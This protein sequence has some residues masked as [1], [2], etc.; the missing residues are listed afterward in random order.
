MSI[1]GVSASSVSYPLTQQDSQRQGLLALT[2][3]IDSGDLSSAQQAYSA[4][5]DS[6]NGNPPDPNSPFGQAL[7]QIG[8]DLKSGDLTGA[9]QTLSTLKKGHAHGHHHHAPPSTQT[10]ESAAVQPDPSTASSSSTS[11]LIDVKA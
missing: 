9:Q 11:S 7:A 5:T 3:A 8:N 6:Q 2:K 4:L 10:A 1:S